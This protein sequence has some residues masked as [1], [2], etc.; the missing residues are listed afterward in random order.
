MSV[1]FMAS[2]RITN[3]EEY[4]LYLDRSEEIFGRYKGSYLA[5]D[6]KPKVLEGEWNYTR[7]VLIRFDNQNDFDAWYRSEDYK[8]IL[9]HRISAAECDTILIQGN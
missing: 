9:K 8:E 2:I 6:N 7:A 4:Q 5:V 1:Y 3:E